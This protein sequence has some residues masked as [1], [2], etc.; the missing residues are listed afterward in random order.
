MY[1]HII[2]GA[3]PS[4]HIGKNSMSLTIG[5]YLWESLGETENKMGGQNQK[6]IQVQ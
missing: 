4:T 3:S 5:I 6:A 1:R 2:L